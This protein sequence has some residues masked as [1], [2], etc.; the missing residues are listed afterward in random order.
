MSDLLDQA[1][2]VTNHANLITQINAVPVNGSAVFA[3]PAGGITGG[4]AIT[5]SGG[6]KIILI[7]QNA[8]T[9][10][11]YTQATAN[12][13]HFIVSG[14][15]SSLTLLNVTLD[16]AW[17][18][19]TVSRGG[20]TVNTGGTF[21]MG[22]GSRITRAAWFG[23]AGTNHTGPFSTFRVA[24]AGGTGQGGGVY[25][26]NGSF[27]LDGGV[28]INNRAQGGVGGN[29]TNSNAGAGYGGIGNGGG[30]FV[31]NS[32]V[33]TVYRGSIESNRA[34][35]GS[36]GVATNHSGL[37]GGA[38]N[39]GGVYVQSGGVFVMHGGSITNYTAEGG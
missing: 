3:L 34:L 8:A 39:G 2:P 24:G 9:A 4:N 25:V 6:R 7:S 1:V 11:V 13:R 23:A 33:F 17:T 36:A 29:G 22:E 20:V 16:G 28:V 35:G 5:V 32:G 15:D 31:T 21:V 26:D 18:T 30:V 10:A 19:G 38:A 27:I 14:A 12:Q 37:H